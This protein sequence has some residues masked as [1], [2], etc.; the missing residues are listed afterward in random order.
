MENAVEFSGEIL[1]FLFPR[2]TRLE[3]AQNFSQRIS[4]H[5]SPDALQLQIPNFMA[6]FALQTFVPEMFPVQSRLRRQLTSASS[7]AFLFRACFQGFQTLQQRYRAVEPP[8]A[9]SHEADV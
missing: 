7:I 4:R 1:L 2:E 6:L 9:V 3:S 5:F 8:Q